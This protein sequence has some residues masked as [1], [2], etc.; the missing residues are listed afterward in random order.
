[1]LLRRHFRHIKKDFFST[2]KAQIE[3]QPAAI[4]GERV[5]FQ[6]PTAEQSFVTEQAEIPKI[7][8]GEIL[9][10]IK[11]ATICGSDIHTFLGKRHEP[12]P[13]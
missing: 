12:F 5:V 6:G 9:G 3:Q 7:N 10:R 11:A 1:M 2:L 4:Y 13:R 8:D